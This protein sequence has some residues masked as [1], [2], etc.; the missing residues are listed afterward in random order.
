MGI[1]NLLNNEFIK[2]GSTWIKW[3]QL[4]NS[5][6]YDYMGMRDFPKPGN[7]FFFQCN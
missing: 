3:S 6:A 2:Y 4:D 1:N 5:M 7:M